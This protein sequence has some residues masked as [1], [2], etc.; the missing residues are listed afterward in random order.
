MANSPRVDAKLR[1]GIIPI[2]P[3]AAA[4]GVPLALSRNSDVRDV[5]RQQDNGQLGRIRR[6]LASLR[7]QD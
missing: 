5:N 1:Q 2:R 3:A 4:P 6:Q 7:A